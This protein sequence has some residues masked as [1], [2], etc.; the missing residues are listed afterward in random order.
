MVGKVLVAFDG[1]EV[2][3]SVIDWAVDAASRWKADLHGVYVIE[4]AWSEG[5]IARELTI[6]LLE[7]SA[8]KVIDDAVQRAAASGIAMTAYLKRGHPGDEIVNCAEDI[9][10]DLIVVGSVGR[11]GIERMLVGSVSAF[12]VTHSPVS[13]LIVRP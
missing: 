13:V 10:A 11:S 2:S 3:D 12:V 8:G 4:E 7:E 9:G 1:S 6:E 5:D